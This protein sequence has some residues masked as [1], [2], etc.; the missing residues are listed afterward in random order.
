MSEQLHASNTWKRRIGELM[1]LGKD[2]DADAFKTWLRVN[3]PIVFVSAKG[4]RPQDFD[5]L[6]RISP[7]GQGK[8]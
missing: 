7:L 5:R 1:E 2:E 8:P 6:V 4:A 3:M